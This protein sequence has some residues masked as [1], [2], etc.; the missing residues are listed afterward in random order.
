M[1][2]PTGQCDHP[3]GKEETHDRILQ[4]AESLFSAK[5]FEATSVRD[6]TT[7]ASCNVASVNYHFGGKENLYLETFRSLLSEVRDRRI[8]SM[9]RD[10]AARPDMSLEDFVESFASAFMEPLVDQ[11]RGRFFLG[12]FAHELNDP[13]LPPRVFVE[14]FIRPL[15][16]VSIEGFERVRTAHGA[17]GAATLP[18][19]GGRSASARPQGPSSFLGRRRAR[20]GASRFAGACAPHH[21][22]L[23]RRHPGLCR[24][25][26]EARRD[27]SDHRGNIMIRSTWLAAVVAGATLFWLSGCTLGPDPARP[28]T[29]ADAADTYVYAKAQESIDSPS[30]TAWWRT[31]GD[32]TT[33]ELV[34]LALQNN[35][36][37]QAAAARVLEAEAALHR[38][39]GARLPQV[40]VGASATDQRFSFVLPEVGRRTI[41]STTYSYNFNVSWQADLLGRLKRTQQA[42]WASLMA[43]EEAQEALVH[44]VVSLVVRSR[45][46]VATAER[47]LE[48]TRQITK[49]WESTTNTVERRYR[50]GLAGAV[51]LHLAR[52]NLAAVR[53]SEA[54]IAGQLDQAR[55]ALDVVVGRRPGSSDPLPD[56]LP[57]LPSLEPVPLGLPA[58]LLDRRPD[59]RQAEM[60]L[61]AATY[62]AGAA[63]ANLYPDLSLTGSIG[64]SADKIND[65]T[66][67]DGLVYN[68]VANLVGPIFSGGQRRADVDA[69]KA[70]VEQATALYAG[71]VLTALRE[72]EDALV[73]GEST[74]LN[75]EFSDLRVSEARA[76]DRLAK[77]RYQRGVETLLTVL[78]TER[79][80]RLAE[81]AIITATADV[82][83]ARIDLFLA[84]GG[85]W[86]TDLLVTEA[87]APESDED[88]TQETPAKTSIR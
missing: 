8:E 31:F 24:Y 61:A 69:A 47:A 16:Q 49:S 32:P 46:L 40:G 81:Q 52:E 22:L 19:V 38:A 42:N 35:T 13:H 4:A 1:E 88:P 86:G 30:V 11:S 80:L 25:P 27:S 65:L 84:L 79:R 62:G 3:P 43:Q 73:L 76:A 15:A 12:F 14:E 48:I 71:A 28:V 7:E 59:L 34:E 21:P 87:A 70:R 66:L 57:E 50:A 5:G 36:D 58:S 18:H 63:I 64:A 33:V 39:R 74:T 51:E 85:D 10:M 29:A 45:V 54:V 82:W 44:T 53:A 26:V 41:D 78:E 83:N 55:L 2:T 20:H 37:L 9:R 17:D 77:Q 23:G 67:D 75:W 60:Q 68:A 56:T 72:V 6:L